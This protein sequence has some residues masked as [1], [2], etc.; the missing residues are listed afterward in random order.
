MGTLGDDSK[1]SK[2]EA[3]ALWEQARL[4]FAA[5]NYGLTRKLDERVAALAAGTE[6]GEQALRE[7]DNL[8]IDR[9]GIYIG[10]GATLLYASAWIYALV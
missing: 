1:Q 6:Q 10:L 9:V 4:A 5:G 8:G 2:R 7:H 3:K